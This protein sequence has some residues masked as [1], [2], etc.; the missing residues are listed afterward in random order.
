[1]NVPAMH[2]SCITYVFG[3]GKMYSKGEILLD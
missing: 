3:K 1:M 2:A